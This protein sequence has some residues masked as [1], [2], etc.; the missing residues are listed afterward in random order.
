MT[1]LESDEAT[2]LYDALIIS[3]LS[4]IVS[5]SAAAEDGSRELRQCHCYDAAQ[6]LPDCALKTKLLAIAASLD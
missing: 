6:A 1:H 5:L 4:L 3:G 2:Q